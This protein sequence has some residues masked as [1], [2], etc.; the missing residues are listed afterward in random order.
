MRGKVQLHPVFDRA[1]LNSGNPSEAVSMRE[2]R[3]REIDI[4][5]ENARDLGGDTHCPFPHLLVPLLSSV[6]SQGPR[7]DRN[8]GV[9]YQA[10]GMIM[11][12]GAMIPPGVPRRQ[13][14]LCV[15]WVWLQQE[16]EAIEG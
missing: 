11:P 8:Q 4:G 12:A 9:Q 6:P 16:T 15:T 3:R 13:T 10:D 14:F 5:I 1:L 2:H 7:S